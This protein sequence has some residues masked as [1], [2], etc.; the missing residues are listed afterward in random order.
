MMSPT[1]SAT[2]FISTTISA[3]VISTITLLNDIHINGP[4]PIIP[5]QG[6]ESRPL[7]RIYQFKENALFM[8]LVIFVYKVSDE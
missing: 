3:S 1:F 4:L 2:V 6:E 7:S 5:V 8:P